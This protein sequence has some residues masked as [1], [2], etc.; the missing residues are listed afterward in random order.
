MNGVSCLLRTMDV[1]RSCIWYCLELRNYLVT[2][3]C[4][5]NKTFGGFASSCYSVTFLVEDL[6]K[7]VFGWRHRVECH[8]MV[9]EVTN[10]WPSDRLVDGM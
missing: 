8:G 1:C 5:K 6:V 10:L 9:P 7:V 2:P 3:F 4:F